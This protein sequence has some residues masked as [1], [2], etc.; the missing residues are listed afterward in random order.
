MHAPAIDQNTMEQVIDT[1]HALRRQ[2]EHYYYASS[3][4]YPNARGT[5]PDWECRQKMAAWCAQVVQFCDLAHET[6]EIAIAMLDCFLAT[7]GGEPARSCRDRYR[8]ACMACLYAAIKNTEAQALHSKTFSE[9]SQGAYS[10]KEL[11]RMELSILTCLDWRV[12]PPTAMAF[13]REMMHLLPPNFDDENRRDLYDLAI[14]QTERGFGAV[15]ASP[16]AAAYAAFMNSVAIVT[17]DTHCLVHIA[18]T[19]AGVLDVDGASD[20]V[21]DTQTSLFHFLPKRI[22]FVASGRYADDRQSNRS[23]ITYGIHSPRSVSE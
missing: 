3:Y 21:L 20:D 13:V 4:C 15:V 8:L 6:A 17:K 16:S 11:E 22:T 12:N 1:I 9:L 2:E 19:M 23:A 7:R 10:V 14:L 5:V 18:N